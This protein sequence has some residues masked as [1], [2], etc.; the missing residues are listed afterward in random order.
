[1][2]RNSS[3]HYVIWTMGDMDF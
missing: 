2:F 1:M 3:I